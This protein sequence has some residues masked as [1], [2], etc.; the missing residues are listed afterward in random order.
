MLELIL[1]IVLVAIIAYG[2]VFLITG[3][4]YA[5][6]GL[7]IGMAPV[8]WVLMSIGVFTG[9]ICTLKNALKAAR[10]RK[11]KGV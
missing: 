8:L 3:M 9:F 5:Y 1:G 7:S 6:W 11:G 4:A 10:E 2:A